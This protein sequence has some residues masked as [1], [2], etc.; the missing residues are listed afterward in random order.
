MTNHAVVACGN[1]RDE[2]LLPFRNQ[3]D[4]F[5]LDQTTERFRVDFLNGGAI[6]WLL[7]AYFN[8][9]VVNLQDRRTR[10]DSPKYNRLCYLRHVAS[11]DCRPCLRGARR[12]G[13]FN[14][15]T[16]HTGGC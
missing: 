2:R 3:L 8:H 11:Y 15:G 16:I 5:G 7:V 10:C 9:D 6:T 14:Y 12:R 1:K 4:E 13:H